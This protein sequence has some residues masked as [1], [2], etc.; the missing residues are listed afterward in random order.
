MPF[1]TAMII[2]E[3]LQKSNVDNVLRYGALMVVMAG[4]SLLF[5]ALA[6]RYGA[7]ASA[8]LACN[9]RQTCTTTCRNFPFPTL[10][11]SAQPAW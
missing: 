1:V 3:G 10:T 9:L 7:A 11:G 5:G 4:L 6:G 8:G 2:D